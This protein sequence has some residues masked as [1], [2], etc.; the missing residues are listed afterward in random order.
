LI[1]VVR[2]AGQV[3]GSEEGPESDGSVFEAISVRGD[4]W[5][6]HLML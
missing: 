2:R 1:R 4:D 5:R 3:R 6:V